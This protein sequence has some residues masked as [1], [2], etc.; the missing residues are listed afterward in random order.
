MVMREG[1][2][3]PPQE[4]C[5]I[6]GV[7]ILDP[8]GWRWDGK[9]WDEPITEAEFTERASRSTQWLGLLPGHKPPEGWHP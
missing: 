7:T 4:W 5:W 2:M 9:D 1:D 6:Q 8:D 3:R